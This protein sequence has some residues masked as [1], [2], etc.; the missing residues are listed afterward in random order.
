MRWLAAGL[1]G[2]ACVAAPARA[3][4]HGLDEGVVLFALVVVV[5]D[6][7]FAVADF[8]AAANDSRSNVWVIPQAVLATPQAVALS[9]GQVVEPYEAP[10]VFFTGVI[11]QLAAFSIYGLAS[12]HVSTSTLY[13]I[14]WGIGFDTAFTNDAIGRAVAGEFAPR[15]VAI[16]QLVASA[17]QIALGAYALRSPRDFPRQREAAIALGAWSSALFVHG[18]LSLALY[19]PKPEPGAEPKPDAKQKQ[20]SFH[21]VPSLVSADLALAPGLVAVGRF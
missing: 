12:P 15:S 5:A 17:P 1:L 3:Q 14:S 20:Q 21:L 18:A 2:A 11:D 10:G 13:G 6:T 19:R 8:V 16:M 9:V 4:A 7:S